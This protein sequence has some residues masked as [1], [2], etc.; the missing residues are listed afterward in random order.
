M[1]KKKF[2]RN[3]NLKKVNVKR[4]YISRNDSNHR[5]IINDSEISNFLNKYNFKTL[6][7]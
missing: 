2:L 6:V 3:I 7:F 1:V 5:K 4:I